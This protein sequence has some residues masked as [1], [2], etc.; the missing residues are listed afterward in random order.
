[1]TTEA[2]VSGISGQASVAILILS[3]C[4]H[5]VAAKIGALF[6]AYSLNIITFPHALF[7]VNFTS[8]SLKPRL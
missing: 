2:S 6:N 4:N 5:P 1:M 3:N 7:S 8:V